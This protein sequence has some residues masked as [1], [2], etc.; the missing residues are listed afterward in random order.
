MN[1]IGLYLH[2]PFCKTKCP[3]CDFYS[4]RSDNSDRDMYT[5]SL[6]ESMETWVDK[7]GRKA[8]TLY[9]GGG[10]PSL[11][12][13][14]NIAMLTRRAKSLFDVDGEI[15]VECNPSAVDDDFFETV[16]DAGVNRI[17]LGVQSVIE[18]ERKMLGRFSDRNAIEKTIF[19]C[20]NGGIKNIS[21]D[22]MLGVQ[23]Q[24]FDSL[25]E[26]LDFCIG[27]GATH[28]SAYML[29]IE[30]GTPYYRKKDSLNLPDDDTVADMYLAMCEKLRQNGFEHY[31]I[32]NFARS[33]FEGKHNLKYWNCEEYLGLG[34][35]AHSFI[36]GKRF[37]FPRD[38]E[39]FKDGGDP[40]PDGNGGDE[41]EYIMLRLRLDD[42]IDFEDYKK[43]FGKI[44]PPNIIKKAEK[45]IE[46]GLM[47]HTVNSLALTEKGFLVSNSII[48]DL[49]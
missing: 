49:I 26:T 46:N 23:N 1:N 31:E 21:L 4:M 17:S 34:P 38:I 12:G 32:S 44:F 2:I 6:V 15:T 8:D 27:S 3:Y 20:V 11:L 25:A 33:G 42:G 10:T 5:I 9:F 30:E 41:E 16:A 48:S 28:I 39:Y 43:R 35:S 29:K 45:F 24:T 40:L 18:S 37:Y 47:K 7:L 22:V 14:E 36:D 13:G 19:R